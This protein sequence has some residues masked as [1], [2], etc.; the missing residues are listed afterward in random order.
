VEKKRREAEREAL[1]QQKLEE[2]L[3]MIMADRKKRQ[4]EK[5]AAEWRR[6]EEEKAARRKRERE[7]KEAAEQKCRERRAAQEGQPQRRSVARPAEAA[8][9]QPAGTWLG[10]LVARAYPQAQTTTVSKKS[11]WEASSKMPFG[12]SRPS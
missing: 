12:T 1:I 3:E 9:T 11:A 5:E 10:E 2:D 6:Q 7:E 4:E 8:R